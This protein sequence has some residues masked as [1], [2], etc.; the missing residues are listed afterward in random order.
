MV[1]TLKILSLFTGIGGFEMGFRKAGVPHEV[2]AYSEIN[3]KSEEVYTRH[4]PGS[5]N[6]GDIS[7]VDFNRVRYN[8]VVGGS[9]CTDL[10][11]A[12]GLRHTNDKR[13]LKGEQSKLFYRFVDAIRTRPKCHFILENVASMSHENRDKMTRVL[14]NASQRQVHLV[15]LDGSQWT[16]QNRRRYFW[17]TWHVP[18][19]PNVRP[20]RWTK[21]LVPKQKARELEHS[22]RAK[23]YFFREI[24][25]VPR[26]QVYRQNNDTSK[27]LA[28]TVTSAM[29]RDRV[30]NLIIDH[31]FNP[32]L[33]RM[34]HLVEAERLM[35]FPDGYTD[36][37]ANVWRYRALGNAVMPDM[38]MYAISFLKPLFSTST[39]KE[40]KSTKTNNKTRSR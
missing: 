9:P 28:R 1:K 18:E 38:A 29:H 35:G 32:P 27:R 33:Y 5:R 30:N 3:P 17:T 21:H 4:F 10:S 36:N 19:Q 40:A 16:G 22:E 34:H 7:G 37:I 8:C 11:S 20:V 15:L 2:V 13:G 39:K 23:R 25:G 14:Q 24:N 26:L 31:R 12:A 6:L